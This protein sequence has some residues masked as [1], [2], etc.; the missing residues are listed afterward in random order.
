M[1]K[2]ELKIEIFKLL[3]NFSQFLIIKNVPLLIYFTIFFASFNTVFK[4]LLFIKIIVSGLA[5]F[6]F[7]NENQKIIKIY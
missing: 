3:F 5:G 7:F 6:Y 1:K 2:Y 4:V